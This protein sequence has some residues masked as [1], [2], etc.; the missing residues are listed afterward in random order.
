[1][2]EKFN[3]IAWTPYKKRFDLVMLFLI[4]SYLVLFAAFQFS[5]HP[6]APIQMTI[7]RGTS[8]LAFIMLHLILSIGPL[9]RL[10]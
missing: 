8:T 4:V 6:E 1:M 3:L 7:I 10:D 2:A 5:F 9:A